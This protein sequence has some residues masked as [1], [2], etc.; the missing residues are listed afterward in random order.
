MYA[1]QKATV[2]TE[3]RETEEFDNGKGVRQGCILSPLLF[4]IYAEKIM[5]EALDKR[6][7]GIGIGGRVVTNLRWNK[8]RPHRNHGENKENKQ[9]SRPTPRLNVLKTKVMTTGDIEQV[10]VDGKIVEVVTSFK[11]IGTLITREGLCDKEI[12]RR[13]AMG[14]AAMGGLNNYMERQGNQACHKS[15]TGEGLVVPNR[16]ETWA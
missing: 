12:H 3:F 6:E 1:N 15:E 9:E 13:I 11:F 14:T 16:A 7:R 8:G 4:N 2:K 5:I 10:K